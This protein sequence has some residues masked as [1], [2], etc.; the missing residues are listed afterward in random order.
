MSR[1]WRRTSDKLGK[2]V[3]AHTAV[4]QWFAAVRQYSG[5]ASPA[6]SST[7]ARRVFAVIKSGQSRVTNDG[8]RVTLTGVRGLR[9]PAQVAPQTAP[10]DCPSTLDCEWVPAPYNW[11]G[12]PDPGAYG[13]HD[14]GEPARRTR[15][16]TTSSSTTPRRSYDEALDLVKDP[17]YLAWN[18][19]IRSSD[20][21]VAQHLDANDVGWHAGNWYVNMHSIGIEHEGFAADGAT[22]FTESMYE[23]SAA[24][25]KYLA[26]EYDVPL[27]RAHIIGHDQVPGILPQVRPRDALGPGARTGTGA[28]TS[29]CWAHHSA[30]ASEPR[31]P[32]CDRA[33]PW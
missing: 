7:F 31:R 20:G 28:T 9:I 32:T 4:S 14:L 19:T 27:D 11:Y 33:A 24:L 18:Y 21:H 30:V 25:V 6:D 17:T 8:Q 29:T 15:T 2:P 10:V 22:W 12:R 23:S 13:N 1:C 26:D 16:S 3:G 5:S